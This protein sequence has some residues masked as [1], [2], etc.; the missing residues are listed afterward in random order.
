[1]SATHPISPTALNPFWQVEHLM[2]NH[3]LL[4]GST[5]GAGQSVVEVEDR[6]EEEGEEHRVLL[7]RMCSHAITSEKQRLEMNGS[8]RHTFFNPAGI[9]FELGC[10]G[11]ANGVSIVGESS[12]EFSWFSGYVWRVAVCARCGTHLG[13]RFAGAR[14]FYG[15]ILK[16]LAQG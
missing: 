15:L 3:W 4:R 5:E 1:M 11:E 12:S 2:H 16:N 7:C 8:H 6:D 10:F 14:T 9:V 13:W